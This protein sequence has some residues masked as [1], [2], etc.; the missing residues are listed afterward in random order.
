MKNTLLIIS[1]VVLIIIATVGICY[2]LG[3]AAFVVVGIDAG[4][5]FGDN[6]EWIIK[7]GAGSILFLAIGY[8]IE[9]AIELYIIFKY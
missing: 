7:I 5:F 1:L 8:I 3:V 4:I 6:A 9:L 2:G